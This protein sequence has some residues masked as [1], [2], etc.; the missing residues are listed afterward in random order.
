MYYAVV[1]ICFFIKVAVKFLNKHKNDRK[2]R[3][4][5]A[6]GQN[7]VEVTGLEPAASCSQSKRATNCATPRSERSQCAV[8]ALRLLLYIKKWEL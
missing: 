6:F 5:S 3:T 2:R 4:K 7:L 8:G 1:E